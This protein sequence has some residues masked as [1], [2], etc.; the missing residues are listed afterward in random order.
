MAETNPPA[1]APQPLNDVR[2]GIKERLDELDR[3]EQEIFLERLELK[4]RWNRSLLATQ[5]PNEILIMIF[6]YSSSGRPLPSTEGMDGDYFKFSPKKGLWTKFMLVCRHW[7]DVARATP[8]LWRTIDVGKNKAWMRL[9]LTRSNGA[10]IDV[11]FSSD[12]DEEDATILEPY[13]DRLRSL[14]L[15]YWSPTAFRVTR[16]SLPQMESFEVLGNPHDSIS[17]KG[18]YTVTDLGITRQR[19]PKLRVLQVIRT[20]L[21][22]DPLFYSHLCRLSLKGCPFQSSLEQFVKLLSDIPGLR[23]LELDDFLQQ[24]SDSGN[25][26]SP[27]TLPSLRSLRLNNHLPTF[28]ARFLSRFIIPAASLSI[29]ATVYFDDGDNGAVENDTLCAILPPN[30]RTS[31]PQLMTV[32]RCRLTT[33][34]EENTIECYS[35]TPEPDETPL[36]KLS[37]TSSTGPNWEC[38]LSD[39]IADLLALFSSAPV[40]HLVT[41]GHTLST[42][43]GVESWVRLFRGFPA[44][45]SLEADIDDMV[46]T[47]FQVASLMSPQ[48][49]PVVCRGLEHIT[50]ND[51]WGHLREVRVEPVFDPLVRCLLY[52]AERGTR[53]KELRLEFHRTARVA[54]RETYLPQLE[55]LVANVVFGN[56]WAKNDHHY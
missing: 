25:I 6:V 40:T 3:K 41:L 55:N 36:V 37:L 56:A 39:G 49:G 46:L 20:P 15:R 52:R 33:I 47:G 34:Y 7:C 9:A 19:F 13:Y 51:E 42:V 2:R 14:R 50:L 28:S 1:P 4:F 26:G 27:V 31:L 11:S 38:R 43:S 12:F 17:P 5:L 53:L 35:T 48:D 45:V 22:V 8:A 24:L 30:F 10:T 16:G 23:H 44:L 29:T 54:V 32:T 18:I 21:P